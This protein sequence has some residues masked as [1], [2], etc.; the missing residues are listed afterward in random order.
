M[1]IAEGQ[2]KWW[3]LAAMSGVLGLVVLDETVVGVA[4]ATI[5]PDLQMSVKAT[6][7]VVNAY[8]L[9]FTSFVAVG[10]RLADILGRRRFFVLGVAVFGLSSAIAGFAQNG[11]WLIAARAVQ[12]I[13]AAIV[14]PSSWAILTSAFPEEQRGF[15]FGIQTTAGGVFMALGPLVGGF[16]SENV[17]WR[18]IFWVNLPIVAAVAVIVWLAWAP[19]M[20]AKRSAAE[21][22]GVDWFGLGTLVGGLTALVVALMEGQGWGWHAPTTL[23]FFSAGLAL[24]MLFALIETRRAS[25]LIELKLLAIPSFNGGVL[26]FFMFQWSKLAVFV[27]VALYLQEI[28]HDSPINAGSIVMVAIIPTLLTSLYSGKS[29]DRFGSRRP[30][31]AGLFLQGTALIVVGVAMIEARHAVIVAALVVWGAAMPFAAVPARRALMNAVPKAR[32]G[33]ASGV[34]LTIQMLGGT[35]GVALCGTLRIVTGR[36]ASIFFLTGAL[37]LAMTLVAWSTIEH[38]R[39]SLGTSINK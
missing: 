12:G 2:R 34:N 13:G 14:F 16:L 37:L 19:S 35:I 15:A 6:D 4:L 25:P 22:G 1:T 10:G 21:A 30:L 7:W 39:G 27:F 26:S 33:E 17:S 20:Q 5:R 9:T 32:Q 8:F 29:A 18:W 31:M 36:Y 38:Q 11:A 3:I 23:V 24:L 28:L